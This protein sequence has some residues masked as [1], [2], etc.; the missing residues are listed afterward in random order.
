M[1]VP[2][3]GYRA[4]TEHEARRLR[5]GNPSFSELQDFFRRRDELYRRSKNLIG[6]FLALSPMQQRHDWG[7]P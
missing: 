2:S 6:D 7:A 3:K 5:T 4:P 1:S